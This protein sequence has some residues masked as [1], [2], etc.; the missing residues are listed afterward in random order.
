MVSHSFGVLR[1]TSSPGLEMEDSV[2]AKLIMSAMF[3]AGTFHPVHPYIP[4]SSKKCRSLVSRPEQGSARIA[5]RD[6]SSSDLG[7][8]SSQSRSLDRLELNISNGIV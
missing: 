7:K 5:V 4:M 3:T 8:N 6:E 2:P 1:L